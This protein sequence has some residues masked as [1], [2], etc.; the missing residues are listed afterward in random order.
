MLQV[1]VIIFSKMSPWN[2]AE[3]TNS[4]ET[5]ELLGVGRG[6]NRVAHE[7]ESHASPQS[8]GLYS[9]WYR[10]GWNSNRDKVY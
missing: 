10:A 1:A 8:T 5:S 7:C 6:S 4:L 9:C 2:S 3:E